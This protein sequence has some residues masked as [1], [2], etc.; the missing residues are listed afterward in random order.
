M[1]RKLPL[2][3]AALLSLFLVA[4]AACGDDDETPSGGDATPPPATATGASPTAAAAGAPIGPSFSGTATATVLLGNQTFSFNNGQCDKAADEAWLAVNIGQVGGSDYF[5]LLVGARPG[6]GPDAKPARGGGEFTD[7]IAL[8]AFQGGTSLLM[9]T[10]EGNKI[11]VAAD[12]Q[13]GDF[14]G[15]TIDGL[16]ISG[17]FHC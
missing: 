16:V 9:A 15:T 12:L 13:S 5:G 17:S 10:G 4:L 14:E 1:S 11:T 7:G 3:T 2:L 8:S 6:A